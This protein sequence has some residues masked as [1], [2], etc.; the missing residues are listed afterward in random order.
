MD[1]GVS[2]TIKPFIQDTL[3]YFDNQYKAAPENDQVPS[4][5]VS[6]FPFSEWSRQ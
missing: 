5:S 1:P 6:A 4:L 3:A 2:E